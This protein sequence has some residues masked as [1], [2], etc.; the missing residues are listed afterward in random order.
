MKLLL[1]TCC[2]PC[3][4][5]PV[6]KA[7]A[8]HHNITA[9][10]FNPNIQPPSEFIRRLNYLQAFCRTEGISL[11]YPPHKTALFFLNVTRTEEP[12]VRC[13]LCWQMRMSETASLARRKGFD[14]FTTTLLASPYQDHETLK[15]VCTREAERH[16]VGFYYHD[17][18]TGFKLAHQTA[19]DQGIYCQN[20]CGCIFSLA[21]QGERR[22]KKKVNDSAGAAR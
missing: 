15:D 5:Y 7:K 10:F 2:A 17:F 6:Q 21:E 1:H 12:H 11:F 16:G 4:L 9:L 19:R 14:A 18:R 22:E 3:A 20:Y 13:P 8:E